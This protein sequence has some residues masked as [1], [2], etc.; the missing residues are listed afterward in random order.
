MLLISE[1]EEDHNDEFLLPHPALVD[2]AA[3]ESYNY[4]Y[5]TVSLDN[6]VLLLPSSSPTMRSVS[7]SAS[8]WRHWRLHCV[9]LTPRGKLRA[10]F[11]A[12]PTPLRPPSC[13]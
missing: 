9:F 7:A 1:E 3:A 6:A 11:C 13:S 12:P 8:V 4:D 5:G 10:F 2:G